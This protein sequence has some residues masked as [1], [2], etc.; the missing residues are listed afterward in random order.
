[1][2]DSSTEAIALLQNTRLSEQER[3]HGIHFLRDHPTPE[4][5]EAL[6]AALEDDD[7]GVRWSAGAALAQLGDAAFPALLEKLAH[8]SNDTWLREGARHVIHDN[9]SPR[10][11]DGSGDLVQALTGPGADIASMEA[12]YKLLRQWK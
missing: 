9:S 10:V 3:E 4:G 5:I 2:I 6:V 12:A 11:R 1:M 8:K 7:A